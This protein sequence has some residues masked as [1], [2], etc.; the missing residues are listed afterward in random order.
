[1]RVW[2]IFWAIVAVF[3][4]LFVVANW[5]VLTLQTSINLL[6][7]QV[8]APLGLVML[9]AMGVL[10][11]FYLLFLVW[12]ETRALVQLRSTGLAKRMDHVEQ[13]V[14]DEIGRI[15]HR[16]SARSDEPHAP[17]RFDEPHMKHVG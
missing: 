17:A 14:R 4:G 6:V 12:L 2:A 15:D 8:T 5:Q 9:G 11:L 7:S 1:M 10:T 3:F 13:V 16:L